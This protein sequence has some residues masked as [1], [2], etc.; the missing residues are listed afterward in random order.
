MG[1]ERLLVKQIG[2]EIYNSHKKNDFQ[3]LQKNYNSKS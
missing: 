2:K 1:K 3:T